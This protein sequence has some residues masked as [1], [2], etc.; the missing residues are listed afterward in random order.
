MEAAASPPLSYSREKLL[1]L[2]SRVRDSTYP[3]FGEYK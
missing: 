2:G 3:S 1:I